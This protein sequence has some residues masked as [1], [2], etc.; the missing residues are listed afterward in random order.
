MYKLAIEIRNAELGCVDCTALDFHT[1]PQAREEALK[2]AKDEACERAD[3]LDQHGTIIF[4]AVSEH[5]VAAKLREE[6]K[7]RV[8]A[9]AQLARIEARKARTITH[10]AGGDSDTDIIFVLS[11][12]MVTDWVEAERS[13]DD[14][15]EEIKD[16]L[17]ALIQRDWLI[18]KEYTLTLTKR[19][20]AASEDAA[21][22]MV[23][24][25]E[26]IHAIQ[27]DYGWDEEDCRLDDIVVDEDY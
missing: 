22:E 1:F 12:D 3:V 7:R 4:D 19:V 24:D 10:F 9:V 20:T 17:R 5:E 21:R 15:L 16:E 23:E 8:E 2:R 27:L 14:D 18:T 11:Q 26:P 13:F 6:T 25:D